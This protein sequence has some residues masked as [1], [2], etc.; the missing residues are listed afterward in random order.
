MS[1][2]TQ[3]IE[4]TN[5]ETL[6]QPQNTELESTEPL[7]AKPNTSETFDPIII[8]RTA[9][10]N[11]LTIPSTLK[12][13]SKKEISKRTQITKKQMGKFLK[14][15]HS[16]I[17]SKMN[18]TILITSALAVAQPV[19]FGAAANLTNSNNQG[20][21]IIGLALLVG[22]FHLNDSVVSKSK[23]LND[24]ISNLSDLKGSQHFVEKIDKTPV[25]KIIKE[26]TSSEI[27]LA[28]NSLGKFNKFAIS[29]YQLKQSS[30]SLTFTTCY[31]AL[32]D[33][34]IAIGSAAVAYFFIKKNENEKVKNENNLDEEINSIYD[35]SYPLKYVLTKI[36]EVLKIRATGNSNIIKDSYNKHTNKL[37][38][39]LND[40]TDS[41]Y[42]ID[43]KSILVTTALL[44]TFSTWITIR[45]SYN[46]NILNVLQLDKGNIFGLILTIKAFNSAASNLIKNYGNAAESSKIVNTIFS[47]GEKLDEKKFTQKEIDTFVEKINSNP[48]SIEFKDVIVD[49]TETVDKIKLKKRILE[50]EYLKIKKDEFIGVVGL[51]GSGK[52]TFIETLLGFN[53]ISSGQII[54]TIGDEVFSK[55]EIPEQ[56]WYSIT[57]YSPQNDEIDY[58]LPVKDAILLGSNI[59]PK[60][61]LSFEQLNKVLSFSDIHQFDL[62]SVIGSESDKKRG[63]DFSGGEHKKISIARAL[64]GNKKILILD[65]PTANFDPI[66][67]NKFISEL[68]EVRKD[69]LSIM[70]SHRLNTFRE[71]TRILYFENGK[72]VEDG[73]VI[74]LIKNQGLFF[75]LLN[76]Q[77][78]LTD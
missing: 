19:I 64:V 47:L 33:P 72:I 58:S 35:K 71:D 26:L 49:V 77:N 20:H 56:G 23:S 36:S 54:I 27:N 45:C 34:F 61:N 48:V 4:I 28:K 18:I 78:N 62:D 73:R 8:E 13:L 41:K 65:E 75:D 66:T 21:L 69:K 24:K 67:E 2:D 60:K 55:D 74:N 5:D 32:I 38:D 14:E 39:I 11:K 6:D 10:L 50:I 7:T 9:I 31:I 51:I 46:I 40:N 3:K 30:I 42:K 63:R 16:E 70:I 52:T 57:G 76:T 44:A 22:I 25:S 17:H 68:R 43:S 59:N 37:N 53:N 29:Y 15:K 1:A 12:N